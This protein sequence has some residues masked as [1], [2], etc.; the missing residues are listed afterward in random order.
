MAMT[1]AQLAALIAAIPAPREQTTK[2]RDF[3]SVNYDD[4]VTF[5][6]HLMI[7]KDVNGWD[8]QKAKRMLAQALDGKA[9]QRLR[10][11]PVPPEG[12][13]DAFIARYERELRPAEASNVNK[14]KYKVAAQ[15]EGETITD[16]G[17]RLKNLFLLAYPTVADAETDVRLIEK[18]ISGISSASVK[19]DVYVHAPATL[20]AAK[21]HANTVLG[22][23]L[24]AGTDNFPQAVVKTEQL[25]A[26]G[27]EGQAGSH[28][29]S[30]NA[31]GSRHG[32]TTTQRFGGKCFYCGKSGH[33]DAECRKKAADVAAG[34]PLRP[35]NAVKKNKANKGNPDWKKIKSRWD[36][37]KTDLDKRYNNLKNNMNSVISQMSQSDQQAGQ[38]SVSYAEAY[39]QDLN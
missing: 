17:N 1:D 19:R 10:H 34:R 31:F 23:D 16:W 9:G 12:T 20:E 15:M 11:I 2:L 8:D 27:G 37:Q 13:L 36:K 29:G 18:F 33:R 26:M 6:A 22:A 24:L 39:G 38:E 14:Q 3:S 30:I 7:V 35:V 21:T 4:W 28:G 25:N 5:K 32:S